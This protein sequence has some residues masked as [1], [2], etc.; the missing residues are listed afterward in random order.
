M[1][2]NYFTYDLADGKSR[3]LGAFKIYQA[4]NG[5]LFI[6]MGNSVTALTMQQIQDLH[7]DV[8]SLPEFD[9]DDFC[10]A[11][12]KEIYNIPA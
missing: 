12:P 1:K 7:I 4:K 8:Y 3:A 11:Y 9:Y 6:L 2:R 10:K 5:K